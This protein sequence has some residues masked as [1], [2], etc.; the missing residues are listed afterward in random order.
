MK[1]TFIFISLLL[2]LLV[3]AC[4][5]KEIDGLNGRVDD[6][7]NKKIATLQ[8]Q[9]AAIDNTLPELEKADKELND[10]I[11]K[12][13]S[14]ATKLEEEIATAEE[15]IASVEE[16]LEKAVKDAD[17]SNSALAEQL[18]NTK[19]EI[20]EQLENA[21]AN[22]S[23][24]L[25]KINS[26][27]GT[28]QSKDKALEDLIDELREYTNGELQNAKN[29]IEGT[30]ATIEQYN[31]VATEI[32]AIKENIAAQN[33]A[34][35]ALENKLTNDINSKIEQALESIDSDIKEA[36]SAITAS[37]TKTVTDAKN[38]IT[39][40]YTQAISEAMS[41]I[42]SSMKSWVNELFTGYYTIAQV[43]AKLA[44]L[45][46]ASA[47]KEELQNEITNMAN[48]LKQTKS[49]ITTAY[50]KA[51]EDAIS[52]NNGVMDDKIAEAVQQANTNLTNR[53]ST[54]ESKISIID[55][56]LDNIENN[57]ATINQQI[58]NINT[59]VETLRATDTE[60]SSYIDNLQNIADN[61]QKAINESN[62]KI[63]KL[64]EELNEDISIAKAEV[65]AEL[66]ELRTELES[67]FSL[68]N[69]AITTLQSKDVELEQ[70]I[71]A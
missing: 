36:V 49:E 16:A 71:T 53:I 41:D 47:T 24:E 68:I 28:M 32:V 17:A 5:D 29:W 38:E 6:I 14:T 34:I 42:E 62:Y 56:R 61:L 30:F 58:T 50:T 21:K 69:S 19:V 11:T 20:L 27:I 43:D 3:V 39:V 63:D 65:L 67:E 18:S 37:Y 23:K 9:V 54:I 35:T 12:L 15:N 4:Y 13:Q 10:Y 1:K 40:A 55:G 8:E 31:T 70:K 22:V 52:K 26:T 66:T 45:N 64:E 59:T 7:E 25:A 60:L 51:I 2:S 57:I 44:I 46:D 48:S 33:S